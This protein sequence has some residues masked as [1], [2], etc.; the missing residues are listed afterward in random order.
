MNED[1]FKGLED[2]IS[3]KK[4][5]IEKRLNSGI[6][7]HENFKRL[8]A[9][10]NSY[11]AKR[12][13]SGLFVI[14]I[15][16]EDLLNFSLDDIECFF[17]RLDEE[18]MNAQNH[19]MIDH[20]GTIRDH[21]RKNFSHNNEARRVYSELSKDGY[22][23]FII[24]SKEIH[25][26][27]EGDD[28][29]DSIFY[30]LQEKNKYEEL[31]D[32]TELKNLIE[33]YRE[34]VK[35]RSYYQNF[36]VSKSGLKSLYTHLVNKGK[37]PQK[38]GEALKNDQSDF[39]SK[40]KNLLENKPED[41][42]RNSLKQFLENKLRH[43]VFIN[44]ENLLESFKRIDIFIHD[45]FGEIHLIEV[46]WVGKS[47]HFSGADFGTEFKAK[48]VNPEAAKQTINYI[49]EL[50]ERNDNVKVGYLVVFDARNGQTK[51]TF[52]N[53]SIETLEVKD[54]KYKTRFRKISDICISNNH[55]S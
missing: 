27:V 34:L 43:N 41:R 12:P 35:I 6:N 51:D 46:K 49:C 20:S 40:N 31:K 55:P 15:Q 52:H 47:I 44:K 33:E 2:L 11:K 14:M 10:F 21:Q 36:F 25:H 28:F 23:I 54:S 39:L 26:F 50:Y 19:V 16:K 48:D 37:I 4:N 38:T 22:I 3:S 13:I 8:K 45:D 32:V 42:L 53:F 24:S 5:K 7:D 18:M 1:Y 17:N 29:G 30:T 9:I